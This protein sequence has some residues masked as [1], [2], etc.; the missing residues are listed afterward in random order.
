MLSWKPAWTL[1]EEN[2]NL[3]DIQLGANLFH[4][5]NKIVELE[6]FMKNNLNKLLLTQKYSGDPNN[7]TFW[8]PGTS[9]S[10]I[11]IVF[12]TQS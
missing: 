6:N 8:I 5:I 1:Y 2:K 9:L 10:A 7:N 4:K 12:L 3:N 11:H